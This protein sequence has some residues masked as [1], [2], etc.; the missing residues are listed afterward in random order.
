LAQI[1]KMMTRGVNDPAGIT[2]QNSAPVAM[3]RE[4]GSPRRAAAA[5][6]LSHKEETVKSRMVKLGPVGAASAA[7]ALALL[8]A[9]AAHAQPAPQ[10]QFAAALYGYFPTLSGTTTLPP[11]GASQSVSIDVD[12]I[13]DNLQFTLMGSF[14]A[15]HG[16]W[17]VYTDLIY[18]DVGSKKTESRGLSIGGV[19]PAGVTATV[20]LDVRGSV[21]A[22]AGLYRAIAQPTFQLDWLGGA[23][24]LDVEQRIDWTATGNVGA[25]PLPERSGQREASATQWDAIVGVKGR[26]SFG[27]GGRW[28]APYYLDVGGGDSKLTWQAMA[29][30][31]YSFG[32]G[33]LVGAWRVLDYRMKSGSPIEEIDFNGPGIAAVFRW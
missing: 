28:F 5:R 6:S 3:G 15:V 14:E 2:T 27:D 4:R 8:A 10:W 18:L 17:G 22:L 9:P 33:E 23:R 29:G 21:F 13:L 11:S 32:W 1:V 26:A 12:Q 16:R 20:D 31:G 19:L 30:I 7:C 24:R 25:L